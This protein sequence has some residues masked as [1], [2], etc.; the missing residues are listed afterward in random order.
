MSVEDYRQQRFITGAPEEQRAAKRHPLV[1]LCGTEEF[2]LEARRELQRKS[3]GL[4]MTTVP[5]LE[6]AC[7]LA[8]REAP[9]VILA[10]DR[11]L[12]RD[13][14]SLRQRRQ[15]ITAALMLLAE[16]APV[17]W[18]G[19]EED[20]AAVA[21]L[22]PPGAAELVPRS[23]LCLPAAVSMVQRHLR[24]AGARVPGH[25]PDIRPNPDGVS[26]GDFQLNGRDFGEVLRHE[27]NNPLT[28]ILGNAELLLLE[29]RRGTI[30]LPPHNLQRLE[31]IAELAVRMREAVRQLSD[32]WLAAE[33]NL[34]EEKQAP[35]EE[36]HWPV[37]G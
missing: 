6:T 13:A 4:S 37:S 31:I 14:P 20:G 9:R 19:G 11:V 32:R 21:P 3:P 34:A 33:G 2:C 18:I 25:A 17:V 24:L 36:P 5:E 12:A 16:F 27:L 35:S 30:H 28:G 22:L 29:V 1:L 8:E 7:R 10:E 23:A 15:A 26:L